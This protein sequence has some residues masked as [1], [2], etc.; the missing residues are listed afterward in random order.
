MSLGFPL[1]S[2]LKCASDPSSM[3]ECFTG[4]DALKLLCVGGVQLSNVS[5]I[6]GANKTCQAKVR[7]REHMNLAQTY[8]RIDR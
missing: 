1:A 7:E 4:I 6:F 3:C 5:F 8:T 2:H